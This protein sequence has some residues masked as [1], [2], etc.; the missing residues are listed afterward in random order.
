MGYS[1]C[2]DI[3]K[4]I[5]EENLSILMKTPV[6]VVICCPKMAV[7]DSDIDMDLLISIR[8]TRPQSVVDKALI[9]Y[10]MQDLCS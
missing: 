3:E 6:L 8:M 4:Y 1:L 7:E 10:Q 2:Q 9:K 5:R